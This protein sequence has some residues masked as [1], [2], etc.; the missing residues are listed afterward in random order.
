[1]VYVI[2][3]EDAFYARKDGKTPLF[4]TQMAG[5]AALFMLGE[6]AKGFELGGPYDA[7]ELM[8]A[9]NADGI[10]FCMA[11][12]HDPLGLDEVTEKP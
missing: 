11:N 4:P 5:A 12:P 2:E 10:P 3:N 8:E 1:V 7:K 9:M 6:S